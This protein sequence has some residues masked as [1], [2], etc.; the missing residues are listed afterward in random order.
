MIL[1]LGS[2]LFNTETISGGGTPAWGTEMGQGD[3]YRFNFEDYETMLTSLVYSS[4]PNP[5]TRVFCP[6]GKGGNQASDYEF[7]IASLYNKVYV[8]GTYVPDAKFVLLVIKKLVGINHI[9]RRTLKYNPRITLDNVNYNTP[10]YDKIAQILG[11]SSNGSWFVSEINTINQD[12]LHFTAHVLDKE[13]KC[14]FENS[15]HRS[16]TLL[17]KI[18][19]NK[20]KYKVLE[21]LNPISFP[22][23]RPLQQISYGAPGTGKSFGI[24]EEIKNGKLDAVRTTFHPDSD[25]S[26]FVGAYK[27][28]MG[29]AKVY[30]AQGPLQHQGNDVE[31]DKITYK[32]VPQAFT[33]AY[34]K[35]WQ[36][37][38]KA[39]AEGKT[40][41]QIL[42]IEEINRGNCAQIFGD[43]FQL[44]DRDDDGYSSYP[45]Q[46]DEDLRQHIAQE[47]ATCE[48]L[49]EN[50][51]NGTELMLPPNLYIWATMNTSDQ[52]LFPIDSA[53]KRRWEW[54][55]MKIS[56]AGKNWKITAGD[57]Q[58]DWWNFIEKINNEI[59][60]ATS[61]DDKKLGYFFCKPNEGDAINAERF[62]GKVIFYLWNDVF[63]DEAPA[64]FNVIE[65]TEP[66][67]DAFFEQDGEVNNAAVQTFMQALGVEA[68]E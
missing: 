9:G 5:K 34:V 29:K 37:M 68:I 32:F 44:L 18:P 3:G 59:A 4:I 1:N 53:F 22:L 36:K 35:A 30:G 45:I 39:N 6:L 67:F 15:S 60:A 52:S 54:K 66:S 41:P 48:D 17:G 61:S 2:A 21:T 26:T 28:A 11:V 42:V 62:V 65:N 50:I 55:Y 20:G 10:C 63:K 56:N 16:E 12:E 33:K 25:Y 58:Y 51:K 27:P 49:P 23:S 64:F 8:N 13:N 24:N 19:N 14:Y 47:L 57:K 7:V 38:S 43:L 31:E 46:A 40:E